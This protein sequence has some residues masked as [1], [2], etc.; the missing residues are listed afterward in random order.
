MSLRKIPVWDLPLRL[1]HWALV[2]AVS[3]AIVTGELG[4]DWMDVHGKAGL[5]IIGLVAFR[6]VWGL[7]GPAHA[8]F[9]RFAPTPRRVA[10]Y[11]RGRWQGLGHNPLGALS[12]FALLA[13][14]AVQGT[15]GLF[16]NDDI[17]FSGPLSGRIDEALVSRLTGWHKQLAW[18]LFGLLALHVAAIVFYLVVKRRNLVKPMVTGWTQVDAAAPVPADAA[19]ARAKPLAFVLALAVALATVAAVAWR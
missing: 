8:R 18:V 5:T 2:A 19:A 17:A 4:G 11:L 12:V 15:T 9:H 7:V 10:D 14:L 1:F 6:I 3:T 13:L 16:S